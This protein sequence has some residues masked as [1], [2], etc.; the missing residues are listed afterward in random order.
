MFI[1]PIAEQIDAA[2][3]LGADMVEL[4]TGRLANAFTANIEQQE[5]AHLREAAIRAAN[6]GLQVNAGHGINYRNIRLIHEIPHLTELNIGHAIIAHAMFV[7]IESAVREM[8]KLME[9]YRG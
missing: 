3:K 8:L 5:V 6:V 9:N 4:H 7:G 1:D 2:A